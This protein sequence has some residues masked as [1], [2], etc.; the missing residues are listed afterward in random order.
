[1]TRILG[2][3][4]L[5]S[6]LAHAAPPAPPTNFSAVW[7][8]N[9]SVT[10]NWNDNSTD[11]TGFVVGARISATTQ[12][13]IVRTT[14]ANTTTDTFSLNGSSFSSWLSND[15]RFEFTVFSLKQ[16]S[17]TA[18][19]E[20]STSANIVKLTSPND[21][22]RNGYIG[23]LMTTGNLGQAIDA[24]L[25][26]LFTD[27]TAATP[28][29][30]TGLPPGL[31][32]SATGRFQGTPTALGIFAYTVS[33]VRQGGRTDTANG[34]ITIY[35]VYQNPPALAA[36]LAKSAPARLVLKNQTPT[37]IELSSWF[38]DPDVKKA[39][40]LTTNQ[41]VID[42]AF[43]PDVAPLTVANFLG[44][45]N[46]G[47]YNNTFFHRAAKN[48]AS[49]FVLQGGGYLNNATAS[50]IVRQPAIR[51]EP[52][53]T[54]V[55]GTVAMAKLG[56]N[57]N[58]ATSEFFINMN[59]NAA[60]LD[61]QNAGFSVFG[62]VTAAGLQIAKNIMAL[63][64]RDYNFGSVSYL[65]DC[66]V[67][68]ADAPATY[69]PAS[70]VTVTSATEITPLTYSLSGS[71]AAIANLTNGRLTLNPTTVGSSEL[72]ITATDIDG[73]SVSQNLQLNVVSDPLQ[74]WLN[75]QNFAAPAEAAASADPDAD[76]LN[77]LLEYAFSSDP[78][79]SN[80]STTALGKII[81][82]DTTRYPAIRVSMRK[83]LP[84]G[85]TYQVEKS[86]TL[87]NQEWTT[88]WSSAAQDLTS[89]LVSEIT[90]TADQ[91][92]FTVRDAD[93]VPTTSSG[94]Y[95]RVRFQIAP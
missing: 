72:I 18:N 24:P 74:Q 90:E 82:Q 89:P 41:G 12:F 28:W 35:P 83:F 58:S 27:T 5:A 2:L 44:Y 8:A 93:P 53:I 38:E 61:I 80:G 85:Y 14:T 84:R 11:E 48:G 71:G 39:A 88:V 59:N 42:I 66:P 16:A 1:M 36:P 6:S 10:A 21:L 4:L 25:T 34:Q 57:P 91:V 33:A 20:Y 73:Q 23:G 45:V 76:G 3:I 95:L 81:T 51:N 30:A 29:S 37:T 69:T 65:S 7:N 64:R 19:P 68:G 47:D 75:E 78:K 22:N 70:L 52:K 79:S 17:S 32:I 15:P 40:R 9:G 54:N 49:N 56:S 86:P 87:E 62:R 43:F 13:R 50:S 31:T 26:H 63:P 77:N 94:T 67:T 55:E 60:N 46:R 92:N